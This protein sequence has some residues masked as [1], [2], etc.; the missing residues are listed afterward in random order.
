MSQRTQ[1][2]DLQLHALVSIELL[3]GPY[4]GGRLI[5]DV[6]SPVV[7]CGSPIAYYDRVPSDGATVLYRFRPRGRRSAP[8][9]NP[10]HA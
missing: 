10:P 1:A 4:D 7:G 2:L 3:G 6:A 5:L 9:R 8:K